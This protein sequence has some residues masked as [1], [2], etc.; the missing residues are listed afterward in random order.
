MP[1]REE[2]EDMLLRADAAGDTESAKLFYDE[3]QRM[4]Q[5]EPAAPAAQ[6]DV[7][8]EFDNLPTWQKPLV[9]ASDL[10][11]VAGSDVGMGYSEKALAGIKSLF[12]GNY[13]E[14]L[15]GERQATEDARIRSGSAGQM[16]GIGANVAA[17]SG[18]SKAGVSMLANV[19]PANLSTLQRIVGTAAGAGVEGGIYGGIN[20]AGHDQDVAEGSREGALFGAGVGGI[21]ESISSLMSR[22]MS[23]K[24]NTPAPTVNQLQDQADAMRDDLAARNVQINP[25]TVADLNTT[26]RNAV[27]EGNP[28]GWRRPVVPKAFSEM[29][30]LAEY[31]PSTRAPRSRA[32]RTVTSA[33]GMRSS[34]TSTNGGPPRTR[35]TN[36]V[37]KGDVESTRSVFNMDPDRGMSLYDF[38]ENRKAINDR[39]RQN[40]DKEERAA[41]KDIIRQM[42]QFARGLDDTKATAATGT[43]QEA[44]GIMEEARGLDHRRLKLEEIG[45]MVNNAERRGEAKS[46]FAAGTELRGKAADFLQDPRKTMGYTPDELSMLEEIARGTPKGDRWLR[47]S[48]LAGGFAGAGIGGGLGTTLGY[49]MAGPMGATIGGGIGAASSKG[50]EALAARQAA[51]ESARQ[52][53]QLMDT[54]ARG[55]VRPTPRAPVRAPQRASADLIRALT[56]LGLEDQVPQ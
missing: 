32:T 24:G 52:A 50:V 16:A 3:L 56:I 30:R 2:I 26:L 40:V 27:G 53:N 44:V 17:G 48:K 54:I 42:D 4:G 34:T 13:D 45:K 36:F 20:A 14:A 51:K 18:L 35:D 7:R 15:Q 39:V 19:N 23:P 46:T 47:A 25:D 37:N 21:G 41:G 12:G 10:A 1:T 11:R 29:D 28:T 43:P 6:R 22:I 5:P 9:A 55:G 31:S 38:G 49:S 8:G 33:D